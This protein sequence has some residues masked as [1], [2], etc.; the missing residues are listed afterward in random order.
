MG[1][2]DRSFSNP[3]SAP[4]TAEAHQTTRAVTQLVTGIK[5]RLLLIVLKVT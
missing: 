5:Y 4:A 3:E 1:K 2:Y